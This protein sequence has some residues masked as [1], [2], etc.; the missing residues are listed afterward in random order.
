MDRW[1]TSAC[2]HAQKKK[3]AFPTGLAVDSQ[4]CVWTGLFGGWAVRRYSPQGVL[5][6]SV[7]FPVANVT[8]IA[9]G[10]ARL[11]TV[12]ATTASSGLTGAGQ[13]LAGGLFYFEAEVPGQPQFSIATESN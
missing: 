11:A 1:P 6:E 4:A 8:K 12:Y 7:A 9:F 3:Q 5:L 13:P 2:L 10:G